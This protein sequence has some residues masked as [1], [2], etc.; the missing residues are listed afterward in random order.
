MVRDVVVV[1]QNQRPR[2][3]PFPVILSADH[4]ESGPVSIRYC[5]DTVFDVFLPKYTCL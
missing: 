3:S 4:C 5:I 2:A 1:L